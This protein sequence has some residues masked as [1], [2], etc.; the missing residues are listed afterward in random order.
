MSIIQSGY[1]GKQYPRPTSP[2]PFNT[3]DYDRYLR[4]RAELERQ[5][6]RLT[7]GKR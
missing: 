3:N 2:K 6:D 1:A 7:R 5:W 4:D